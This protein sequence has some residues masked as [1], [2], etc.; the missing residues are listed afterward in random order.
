[1]GP[2][3]SLPEPEMEVKRGAVEDSEPETGLSC[4]SLVRTLMFFT[5]IMF[6]RNLAPGVEEP[7]LEPLPDDPELLPDI[8]PEREDSEPEP[9]SE[10]LPRLELLWEP[11]NMEPEPLRPEP[12]RAEAM[13]EP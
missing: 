7:E 3:W 5:M 12:L 13:P 8:E 2:T 10:P 4:C 11:D 6:W 1:V 9:L